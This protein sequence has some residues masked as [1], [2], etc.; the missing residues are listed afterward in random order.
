MARKVGDR[1]SE[2]FSNASGTITAVTEVPGYPGIFEYDIEWDDSDYAGETW[3][4]DELHTLP[5][6]D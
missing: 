3:A 4:E 5:E 2:Y 1:V 6:S